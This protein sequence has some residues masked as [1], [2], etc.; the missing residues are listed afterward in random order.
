VGVPPVD[1]YFELCE[2]LGASPLPV[3][4]AGVCCQ[5]TR[6]GPQAIPQEE[7]AAYVQDVLDLVEFANG[8]TD[9]GW[10][11]RRAELGHPE[12][13]GLR[14]LGIGN[15]DEITPEFADRFAQILGAVR[16]AHPDVVVVGT[17]G[18]APFGKDF[19]EGWRVARELGV[20]VVDEHGYRSPHWWLQ[21]LDRYDEQDRSGPGVYFGEYGSWSSRLRSALSEAAFMIGMERNGD[22][23]RLASYA[24]LLARVG[25]TQWVPDL[26]YFT[27]TEVRR[28]ASFHVQRMFSAVR[29]SEVAQVEVDGA[30]EVVRTLP[31]DGDVRLRSRGADVDWSDVTV[32]GATVTPLSTAQDGEA[33]SV[34]HW[35]GRRVE[36]S[37][38]LVRR[39]GTLGADLELGGQERASHYTVTLGGWNNKH[40]TVGRR[41]DGIGNG[42]DD[43][44]PFAGVQT[45]VPLAVRVLV[46][47]EDAGSRVQVWLDGAL[48]HDVL[49]ADVPEQRVAVGALAT[50]GDTYVVRLVN[51]TEDARD[52]EL[53]TPW[54]GEVRGSGEVLAGPDPD[55]GEAFERWVHE[56]EPLALTGSDGVLRTTLPPWSFAVVTIA[57][58]S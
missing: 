32:N 56:P 27:E 10:G 1:E 2:L 25:N 53:R 30:V 55:E 41:D 45:D 5:N 11:A 39:D 57:R 21:H 43:S 33:A 36:V 15:E 19:D 50:T 13:F 14:Y 12:P 4:A 42:I 20:D 24:P 18:P 40:T 23:V 48:V 51:S 26:V 3:L 54:S 22:V 58:E 9:T 49:D 17:S 46:E 52:L 35:D 28:T 31:D 37:A 29:G 16:D 7:M 8:G 44:K 47:R 34:G 6:G 38:T